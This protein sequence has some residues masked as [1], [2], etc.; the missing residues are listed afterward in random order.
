MFSKSAVIYIIIMIL[1]TLLYI[2]GDFAYNMED[3]SIPNTMP[4]I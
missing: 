4:S 3:V 2:L 1:N